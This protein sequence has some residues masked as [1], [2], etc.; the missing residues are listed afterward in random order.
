[1]SAIAVKTDDRESPSLAVAAK[2]MTAIEYVLSILVKAELNAI[3]LVPLSTQTN[4]SFLTTVL[5]A[6]PLVLKLGGK[7]SSLLPQELLS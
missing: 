7:S 3:H 6:N 5:G 1:M 4:H 2:V